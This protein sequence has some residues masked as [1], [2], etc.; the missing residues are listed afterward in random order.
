MY[1][2]HT[3]N[4]FLRQALER[5]KERR[6]AAESAAT[7]KVSDGIIPPDAVGTNNEELDDDINVLNYLKQTPDGLA[8]K[9]Q[10]QYV[11]MNK[12]G[13]LSIFQKNRCYPCARVIEPPDEVT[14]RDVILTTPYYFTHQM[15]II[16]APP[17]I[18]AEHKFNIVLENKDIRA[19]ELLPTNEIA[20]SVI[21][22]GVY[23]NSAGA[24]GARCGPD[25][26]MRV[27]DIAIINA[28]L[29]HVEY[30]AR[31]PQSLWTAFK[32]GRRVVEGGTRRRRRH[33]YKR[34]H[35]TR[36][37]HTAKRKK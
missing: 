16:Y 15:G 10:N 21:N 1:K 31:P 34:R 36:R 22:K 17:G 26:N 27:Y 28:D 33:R 2:M 20:P 18:I 29:P 7:L 14:S 4:A 23:D 3:G 12:Q 6:R 30:P 13:K 8:I 25:L 11:L 5:E 37:R 9:Y 32:R 19:I 35:H 24:T